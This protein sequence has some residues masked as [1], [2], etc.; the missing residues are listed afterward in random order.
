MAGLVDILD[1]PLSDGFFLNDNETIWEV[2]SG[3]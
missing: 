3:K 2:Y 1:S